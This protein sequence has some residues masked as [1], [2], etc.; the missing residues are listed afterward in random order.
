MRQR[1]SHS[2]AEK[3]GHKLPPD[4]QASRTTRIKSQGTAAP[5]VPRLAIFAVVADDEL[6]VQVVTDAFFLY[7]HAIRESPFVSHAE[8]AFFPRVTR[9]THKWRNI[10]Y[11]LLFTFE[12]QWRTTIYVYKRVALSFNYINLLRYR[13]CSRALIFSNLISRLDD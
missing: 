7:P 6:V 13:N 9:S 1:A 3:V 11:N 5:F 2:N 4:R 10:W 12:R 8:H